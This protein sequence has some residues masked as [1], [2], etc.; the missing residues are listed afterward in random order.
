MG[1]GRAKPNANKDKYWGTKITVQWGK[2]RQYSAILYTKGKTFAAY[3]ANTLK[4]AGCIC[5]SEPF[6]KPGEENAS[7][8]SSGKGE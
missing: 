8:R 5:K 6:Y 1:N 7:I 4:M 2:D 3:L